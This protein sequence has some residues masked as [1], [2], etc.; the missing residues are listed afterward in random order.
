IPSDTPAILPIQADIFIASVERLKLALVVLRGSA[1]QEIGE[2]Q[3]RLAAEEKEVAVKLS[4][5]KS[6]HLIVME[7]SP[8]LD[9]V[10]SQHL[11]EIVEPLKSIVH[12]LEFVRVG[13]NREAVEVNVLDALGLGRQ[14]NDSRC[15]RPHFETL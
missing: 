6:I 15:A 11:R 8:N 7:F 4:N 3:T 13:P 1:Q 2:I 14:R 10:F 9:R 5:R 12:L